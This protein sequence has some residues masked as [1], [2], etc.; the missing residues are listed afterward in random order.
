VTDALIEFESVTVVRGSTRALDGLSLRI[1]DG[2]HVAVLGSNGSGKSTL[3][4]LLTRE[5]YPLADE[6]GSSLRIL[7]RERWELF[8][9]RGLLGV[10]TNELVRACTRDHTALQTAL[11][12]FFGSIGVWRPDE[13]TP[14]M[15][16]NALAA[17]ELTGVA[18]LAGRPL[19][20]M[21][22]GE[23]RRSVIA[24]A[25]V[26]KPRTLVLDEPMNSLD[27]RARRELRAAISRLARAGVGV[28]L[29]THELEDIVPEITRIITL[30]SG[31][32]LH[33]GPK[34]SVL[35]RDRLSEVFGVDIEP[36]EVGGLYHAW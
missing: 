8:E 20:E 22:S 5:V 36:R 9:L 33:D 32:V 6:P 2:E 18:H 19:S 25:L 29:V 31:R 27:L 35:V 10:V 1:E 16:A 26:H 13:V 24:R 4:E 11:S 17:L 14:A 30:R 23:A 7:G 3:V 21:S 15:E 28:V 12:G 34:A